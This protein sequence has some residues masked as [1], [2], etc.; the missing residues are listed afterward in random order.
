MHVFVL[1]DLQGLGAT[2]IY[3]KNSV[4]FIKRCISGCLM[5]L[6]Y[7]KAWGELIIFCIIWL[8]PLILDQLI[9]FSAVLSKTLTEFVDCPTNVIFISITEST[10]QSIDN[11]VRG[12]GA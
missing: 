6:N 11:V 5:V 8:D 7:M 9:K 3:N 10:V 1:S 4:N 12:T 2:T